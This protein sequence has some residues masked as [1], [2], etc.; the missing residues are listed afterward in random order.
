MQAIGL[1]PLFYISISFSRFFDK[2]SKESLAHIKNST[3]FA[4]L[5]KKETLGRLAQLV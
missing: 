2:N 5:F 3:I 1:H 4:S